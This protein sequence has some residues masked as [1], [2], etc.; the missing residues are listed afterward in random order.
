[1]NWIVQRGLICL[2]AIS[3]IVGGMPFAHAMPCATVHHSEMAL[4]QHQAM[5][6]HQVPDAMPDHAHAAPSQHQHHSHDGKLVADS[7]NCGCLSLC[8]GDAAHA[9]VAIPERRTVGV[10][11]AIAAQIRLDSILWIDPGIPILAT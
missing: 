7:C 6:H 5:G 4:D 11:Y 1:M 10:S 8:A 9:R 2:L 3:L